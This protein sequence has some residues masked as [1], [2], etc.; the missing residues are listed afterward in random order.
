MLLGDDRGDETELIED[1]AATVVATVT[2][3]QDD[4]VDAVRYEVRFT[5]GEDGLYRFVDGTWSQRCRPGRGHDDQFLAKHC[6]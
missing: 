3:L 1:G 4:S 6:L 2:G 5:K